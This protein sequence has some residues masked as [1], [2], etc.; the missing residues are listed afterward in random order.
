MWHW[1]VV[2]LLNRASLN[3]ESHS[4]G[5][6]KEVKRGC[7]QGIQVDTQSTNLGGGFIELLWILNLRSS[8]CLLIVHLFI[9]NTE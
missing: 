5:F 9:L 4:E 6:S 1:T 7:S 3:L 2:G 8:S